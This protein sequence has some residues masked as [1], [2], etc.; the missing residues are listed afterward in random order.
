MYGPASG[1]KESHA[2]ATASGDLRN[3]PTTVTPSQDPGSPPRRSFLSRHSFRPQW[4]PV[5]GETK[6]SSNSLLSSTRS[7]ISPCQIF[8]IRD[9]RIR[10]APHRRGKS[11]LPG[12][13]GIKWVDYPAFEKTSYIRP[14]VP[15]VHFSNCRT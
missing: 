1:I 11:S 3:L 15:V 13:L 5:P 8:R 14:R 6:K 2:F 7:R 10:N 4:N 9:S 12:F